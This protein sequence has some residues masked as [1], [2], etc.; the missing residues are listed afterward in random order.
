MRQAALKSLE[1]ALHHYVL[2][3]LP[4]YREAR[5]AVSAAL[6]VVG[7]FGLSLIPECVM[8]TKRPLAVPHIQRSPRKRLPSTPKPLR[9]DAAERIERVRSALECLADAINAERDDSPHFGHRAEVCFLLADELTNIAAQL[10]REG[11]Q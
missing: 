11:L 3:R 1:R 5:N 6:V 2:T 4:G 9:L 8:T 7:S 10:E